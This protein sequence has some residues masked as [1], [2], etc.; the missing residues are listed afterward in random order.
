M[1]LRLHDHHQYGTLL[2]KGHFA[3][4]LEFI[5]ALTTSIRGQNDKVVSICYKE[6][7]ADLWQK[8]NHYEDGHQLGNVGPVHPQTNM[9]RLTH[10]LNDDL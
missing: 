9:H 2:I 1:T 4:I 8:E 10:Q 6:T 5:F 7:M 3:K